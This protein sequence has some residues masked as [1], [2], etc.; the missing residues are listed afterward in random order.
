M[1]TR[2]PVTAV[3]VEG[4]RTW[5]SAR[6][7][8]AGVSTCLSSARTR[9]QEVVGAFGEVGAPGEMVG[10]VGVCSGSAGTLRP[11]GGGRAASVGAGVGEVGAAGRCRW[12]LGLGVG[13]VGGWLWVGG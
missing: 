13:G 3:E 7:S 5:R 9:R 8:A 6:L 4:V 10:G 1:I 2:L 12:M 11:E